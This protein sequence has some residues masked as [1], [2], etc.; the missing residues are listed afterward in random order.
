MEW[1]L[2]KVGLE[3]TRERWR[4]DPRRLARQPH[5]DAGRPRAGGAGRVGG[6]RAAATWPCSPPPRRTTPSAR[7]VG[8]AGL[9][10]DAIVPL[11]TDELGRIVPERLEHAFERA[12][13]GGR[14]P[15]ALVASA[16]A[17][18]PGFTTTCE[19]SAP[20]AA[21]ASC[22]STW[23]GLTAPRRSCP[24]ATAACS[25]GSTSRLDGLGRAQD[26]AHVEPLRRGAGPPRARPSPAPSSQDASYLFYEELGSPSSTSS[27]ARW[28]ARR[29]RSGS[30][31][32]S[33]WPGGAG[34][35]W[36]TYLAGRTTRPC[37]FGSLIGERQGFECPTGRRATS[38]ASASA[39]TRTCQ[40][41]IRERLIASGEFHLSSVELGGE[42]YLRDR[43]DEPGHR[44][45]HD[46][47]AARRDRKGRLSGE[48]LRCAIVG[49]SPE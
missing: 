20:S 48:Y 46:R 5:R 41:A 16:C 23:T 49:H 11:E 29:H 17:P 44:R 10:E 27:T 18:A 33:T 42:R 12:R 32:S 36:A 21:R 28:S 31:C 6:G 13:E 4:A 39:A 30:S 3:R 7:S 14:R 15:F 40:V 35:A 19:R 22:G 34:G 26:A 45:G 9:G 25:T 43:G 38:S 47:A 2:E 24:I 8:I 1:M 37:G